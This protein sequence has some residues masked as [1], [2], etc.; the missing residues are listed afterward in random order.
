MTIL[1]KDAPGGEQFIESLTNVV[2][3]FSLL[4]A[5]TPDDKASAHLETYITR[6][7]PHIEAGVGADKAPIIMNAF[8]GAVMAR[9]REIEGVGTSRA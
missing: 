3:D 2:R 9:K 7:K 5:G 4:Y 8:R 1:L 6:I